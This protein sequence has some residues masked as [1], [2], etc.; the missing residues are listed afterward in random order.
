[1]K[2]SLTLFDLL[3][4]DDVAW[5][6]S[7]CLPCVVAPGELII[8]HSQPGGDLYI[9]IQGV[10]SVNSADGRVL[11][12]LTRG[13]LFGEVS[14]VDSKRTVA[15]VSASSAGLLA[16]VPKIQLVEKLNRDIPFSARFYL[17]VARMLA[18]R[19]RQNLLLGFESS[20]D[21]LSDQREFKGEVDL[22]G[23]D[24]TARAGARLESLLSKM[25]QS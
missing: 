22:E 21:L 5:L 11:G 13:D 12:E 7:V 6:N 23:L 1:M 3:S 16:R 24:G 19:L 8:D 14:F 4:D 18:Y 25:N 17:A 15:R 2:P 9:V 10:Y 20:K